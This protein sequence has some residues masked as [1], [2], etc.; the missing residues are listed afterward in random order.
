VIASAVTL[1]TGYVL[2]V[3]RQPE[4]FR[5]H[6]AEKAHLRGLASFPHSLVAVWNGIGRGSGEAVI[7]AGLLMLI[8]TPVAGLV[9]SA[10][11]FARRRDWLFTA[12]AATVFG[13]ILGSF[14]IGS[15]AG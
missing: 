14:L 6:A 4:A 15:L 1:L 11:A 8:G 5:S 13:V 3:V 12:I 2:G 9:A 10:L 7:V